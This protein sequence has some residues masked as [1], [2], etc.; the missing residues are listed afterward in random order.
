VRFKRGDGVFLPRHVDDGGSCRLWRGT[1]LSNARMSQENER[2]SEVSTH[3][4]PFKS[5]EGTLV[6]AFWALNP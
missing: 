3:N 1:F 4:N 5:C 2:K 6:G